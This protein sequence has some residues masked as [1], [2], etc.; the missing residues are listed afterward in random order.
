MTN[1]WVSNQFNKGNKSYITDDMLTKLNVHSCVMTIQIPYDYVT[2]F[3]FNKIPLN[4]SL[5]MTQFVDLK[6]I[7]GQL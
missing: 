2:V 6:A 5:V 3:E 1:L 4:G 7:K